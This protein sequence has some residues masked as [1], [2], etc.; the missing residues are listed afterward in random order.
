MRFGPCS[1]ALT[2]LVAVG[3]LTCGPAAAQTWTSPQ[4]VAT[5]PFLTGGDVATNGSTATVV[6]GQGVATGNMLEVQAVVRSG[7]AWGPPTALA[8]Q[9]QFAEDFAVAVAP[10]GDVVAAWRYDATTASNSGVAQVAFFT[11]GHRSSAQTISTAGLN[12]GMPSI[13]FD[14]QSQ[15]T[16]VWEQGTSSSTCAL[17]ALQGSAGH[18]FGAA[19]TL[20]STCYGFVD[21]AVNSVGQAVAVQGAPGITTGP[22]VAVARDSNGVWAA[23]VTLATSVYRQRQPKVG[24]GK[25]GTAVVVWLTRAGV[26]YAT[27]SN[28]TW[29]SAAP[30]P[31]VLS[32]RA[33]GVSGVAVDGGGNAVA[34]FTLTSLT[35]GIFATY[36]PVNGAW[37]APV[38]IPAGPSPIK[39][40]PAGTFIVGSGSTVATR[41]AGSSTWK[42]TSFSVGQIVDVAAGPG[43]AIVT[44]AG[45]APDSIAVSTASVP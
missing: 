40:S 25:E 7:G 15:A 1:M 43:L 4:V 17:K 9:F 35:P 23:P 32:G 12:A 38:Q 28:A 16:V 36:K 6:F 30:L 24:L 39:A 29:S 5:V 13:A 10:N 42:S 11:A 41:L 26:S 45:V 3:V 2:S 31:G 21:L 14:G 22:I 27:R 19:Q 8:P 20:S 33:G 34:T 18:G 37:Q 44:L